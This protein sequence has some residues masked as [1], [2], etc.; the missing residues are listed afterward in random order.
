MSEVLDIISYVLL[1][2]G[3]LVSVVAGIGVLRL[4]DLFSRMHAASMLD[5]L[6]AACILGGL[7]LQVGFTVVGFKLCMVFAFLA[8]TT[9]TA[10]HALAKSALADGLVPYGVDPSD[11]PG[12][13]DDASTGSSDAGFRE[14]RP[15]IDPAIDPA[16]DPA[17]DE[18]PPSPA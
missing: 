5:T 4:P 1:V 9:S 15:T 3:G 12:G 13:H 8:I 10:A 2:A 16:T 14:I 6:G 18:V 7:I 17:I 11:L